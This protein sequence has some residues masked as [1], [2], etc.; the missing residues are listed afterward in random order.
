MRIYVCV[1]HVPDTAAKIVVKN[2][3]DIEENVKFVINPY[4]EYALEE[5]LR[6]KEKLGG[7]VV[8]VMLAKQTAMP[9]LRLALAM[10]ADRGLLI[11]CDQQL[12]HYLSG[13]ALAK[14]IQN[15]GKADIVFLGKQSV[16]S[17]GMQTPYRVA[18][19]L[20]MMVA[21]N[22]LAFSCEAN[23]VT[24]ESEG[25]GGSRVVIQMQIPCVVAAAKGLNHPRYPK[26]P[27]IM[28]AKNKPVKEMVLADLGLD[29]GD[30]RTTLLELELPAEKGEGKIYSGEPAK[31]MVA[32]LV[33][34]LRE[35]A[36][37][38]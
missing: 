12:D 28:K 31:Q 24:V 34:D 9:T 13:K 33:R 10:G 25:E 38:I 19:Y 18:K 8:V 26:L 14:A 27:D 20:D 2:K 35:N 6:L 22:I 15:D 36:R 4:D 30:K 37:V 1:K 21:T 3:T 23:S 32:S 11:K 5:A 17:E 16:D 29:S 7:E